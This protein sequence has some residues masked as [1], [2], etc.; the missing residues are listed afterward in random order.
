MTDK[1][2]VIRAI[3]CAVQTRPGLGMDDLILCCAPYSWNQVFLALDELVRKGAVTM[4]QG[5]GLYMIAPS[6]N[7]MAK[8]VL[9]PKASPMS[10]QHL[11][12]D[13]RKEI[14]R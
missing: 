9:R 14:S 6:T 1:D 11:K 3:S 7:T 8:K 2:D 10:Q 13:N 4:R 12:F 5:H